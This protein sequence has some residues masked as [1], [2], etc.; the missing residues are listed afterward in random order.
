MPTANDLT[1]SCESMEPIVE[2]VISRDNIIDLMKTMLDGESQ[3]L[4]LDG[5]EGIGKTSLLVQFAHKY[6]DRSICCFIKPTCRWTYK[7]DYFLIDICNQINS[8]VKMIDVNSDVE[9]S[10]TLYN[11][12]IYKLHSHASRNNIKFYFII[13]GLDEIPMEDS[14]YLNSILDLLPKG[15]NMFKFILTGNENKIP[16]TF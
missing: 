12:L 4:I 1:V 13:D 9:I 15:L 5:P 10:A 11:K 7:P 2:P 16:N 3:V 6:C 8:V 14:T